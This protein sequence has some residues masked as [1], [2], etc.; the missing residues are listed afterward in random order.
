ML[1]EALYSCISTSGFHVLVQSTHEQSIS[2]GIDQP[3]LPLLKLR[4]PMLFRQQNLSHT[5]DPC[6]ENLRLAVPFAPLPCRILPEKKMQSPG[7]MTASMVRRPA[8]RALASALSRCSLALLFRCVPSA[9]CV[10]PLV[11]V[12][13]VRAERKLHIASSISSPA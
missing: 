10:A 3:R 13:G 9:A 12:K 5:N 11:A 7:S 1:I 2:R 4:P 6:S 8:A